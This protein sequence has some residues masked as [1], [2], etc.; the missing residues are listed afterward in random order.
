M[1]QDELKHTWQVI[2][3]HHDLV[4]GHAT[5]NFGGA[6]RPMQSDQADARAVTKLL[7]APGLR[8]LP[9]HGFGR[10]AG[11]LGRKRHRVTEPPLSRWSWEMPCSDVHSSGLALCRNPVPC[12][13]EPMSSSWRCLGGLMLARAAMGFQFQS[14]AA[15][16]P[17]IGNGLSLDKTQL[18]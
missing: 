11:A 2:R 7:T 18:D 9:A 14:I 4:V 15:V 3:L 17:L 1:Q 6:K 10:S 13:R 16:A 5:H 12:K 8:V